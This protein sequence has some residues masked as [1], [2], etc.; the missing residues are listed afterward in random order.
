M[1]LSLHILP[2][3]PP[4]SI[5]PGTAENSATDT[6]VGMTSLESRTLPTVQWGVGGGGGGEGEG[7]EGERGRRA[8][9]RIRIRTRKRVRES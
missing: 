6:C 4:P 3:L 2:P 9:G 1:V 7:R 5:A 8:N